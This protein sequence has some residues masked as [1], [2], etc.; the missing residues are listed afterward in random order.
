MITDEGLFFKHQTSFE[1]TKVDDI[2]HMTS[3]LIIFTIPASLVAG[4]Y[5]LQLRVHRGEELRT[6]S[7]EDKLTVE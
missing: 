7:L 4:K 5:Q 3:K 6:F 2:I 1:D